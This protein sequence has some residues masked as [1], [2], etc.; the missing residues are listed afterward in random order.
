MQNSA[1]CLQPSWDSILSSKWLTVIYFDS[2][3]L[4]VFDDFYKLLISNIDASGQSP[5]QEHLIQNILSL[6]V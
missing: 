5:N 3:F 1:F 4:Y 2:P 6:A